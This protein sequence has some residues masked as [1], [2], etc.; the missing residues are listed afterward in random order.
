MVKYQ[1]MKSRVFDLIE[2]EKEKFTGM[3]KK[4][5]EGAY[6]LRVPLRVDVFVGDSW[7]KN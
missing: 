7:Y 6:K 4:E 1:S 2:K 3:V 5:M